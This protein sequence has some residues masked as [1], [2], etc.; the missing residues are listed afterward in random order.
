MNKLIIVLAALASISAFAADAVNETAS[1]EVTTA[2][3]HTKKT[4]SKKQ[5]ADGS[6]TEKKMEK[7]ETKADEAVKTNN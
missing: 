5:N 3:K 6:T 2:K 4:K 1:K 7:T